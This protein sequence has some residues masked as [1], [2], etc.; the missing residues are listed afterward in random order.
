MSTKFLNLSGLQHL[1]DKIKTLLNGKQ[2][3]L[4]PGDYISIVNGVIDTV[5]TTIY[6]LEDSS[7]YYIYDLDTGIY[8]GNGITYKYKQAGSFLPTDVSI[9]ISGRSVIFVNR[10]DSGSAKGADF[11]IFE[12]IHN[13]VLTTYS[14]NMKIY[15]GYGEYGI[16]GS[17]ITAGGSHNILDFS[18][19]EK[20]SNKVTSITSSSTDTEY[21]SAKAVYE[22]TLDVYSSSEQIVG[23][24]RN[25]KPL[26]Q[27]TTK[28]TMP[29]TSTA[30]NAS[31]VSTS[32]ADDIDFAFVKEAF[33]ADETG[34]YPYT[35]NLPIYRYYRNSASSLGITETAV[36]ISL[37][38]GDKSVTVTNSDNSYAS[39]QNVY[40]TYCYTKS[41][42]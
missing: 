2:D 34:S 13:K 37:L 9:P 24:W 39:S 22:K 8:V 32:L 5:G 3:V 29:T 35:Q 17:K 11:C 10:Q 4:T 1:V 40:V 30:G 41:T 19:I 20:T 12:Y 36:Y 31:E 25:G 21:P 28:F 15:Y 6:P 27:K 38:S 33:M 7:S 26:Y 18:T 23:T 42:D 14:A 16:S